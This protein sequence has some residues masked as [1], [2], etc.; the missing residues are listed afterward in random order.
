MLKQQ[1]QV[2]KTAES[3]AAENEQ[4]LHTGIEQLAERIFPRQRKK[5]KQLVAQLR[6]MC[7]QAHDKDF[8]VIHSPGGWG[9]T[10]WEEIQDWEQSIVTGVT[11]T[12][13]KLGY[14]CL[15]KQYF[16]S[17]DA[18]WGRKN[19]SREA[20][21]FLTGVSYRA[22]VFAEELKFIVQNLPKLKVILVGASQGAAFNNAAMMKLENTERIYSI[23]LGTFFSHMSRRKITEHTLAIDSNGSMSDPMCHRNLRIATKAY[24]GAFYRWFKFRSIG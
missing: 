20:R 7:A 2:V 10:R 4:S 23:E 6:E 15:I 3:P 1:A 5:H 16:R 24:L 19:V 12:L 18:L 22:G 14:S 13:E 9:N 17:G 21:F 11:A 8:L